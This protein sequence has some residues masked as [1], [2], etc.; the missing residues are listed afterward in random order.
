[1]TWS[2]LDLSSITDDLI[3]LL[4]DAVKSGSSAWKAPHGSGDIDFF[5]I[6]I[7]GAMPEADREDAH[8]CLLSLYLLHVSQ[9]PYYRSAPA[10]TVNPQVNRQ[11]PLSL[12]LYFLLSA[13]AKKNYNHEQQAMSIAL[14][15]FHENAIVRKPLG[16]PQGPPPAAEEYTLTMETQSADEMSRLWQ[17]LSTPLR[18]GVVYKAS[19]VFVTPSTAATAP[20]PRPTAVALAVS[21]KVALA[22]NAPA[23]LFGAAVRDSFVVP[24]DDTAPDDVQTI[25]VPGLVRLGDTLIV[26]GA[27]LDQAKYDKV[28]LTPS[29]GI[30]QEVTAWRSGASGP[31]DFRLAIPKT[32]KLG[33]YTL[34]IGSDGPTLRSGPIPITICARVDGLLRPPELKPDGGGLYTVNGA[35]F[36]AADTRVFFGALP[37]AQIAAGPNAGEFAIDGTGTVL[38][39]KRPN[40]LPSG[41]YDLALRVDGIDVPPVWYVLV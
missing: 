38:T 20:Q 29:G 37:L 23:R 6:Q 17:A 15:C 39:F 12:N 11:N 9:D 24:A 31:S 10:M 40:A 27:G 4:R 13:Y 16:I 35:G 1:M 14:R 2:V 30:E 28:F 32:A 7:S 34:T 3:A 22:G 33:L 26:T 36:D 18:M 19:I 41:R 8:G 5:Q 25:V 21:P